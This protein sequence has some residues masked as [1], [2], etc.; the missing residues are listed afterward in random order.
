MGGSSK[1]VVL[2]GVC[3]RR[4]N[5][6]ISLKPSRFDSLSATSSQGL[7]FLFRTSHC[8]SFTDRLTEISL[9]NRVEGALQ[10]EDVGV[11]GAVADAAAVSRRANVLN[12]KHLTSR[13]S[14]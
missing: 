4:T 7:S 1:G 2:V 11:E 5:C 10:F 12:S 13:Y 8:H 6:V 14:S 9:I 3:R